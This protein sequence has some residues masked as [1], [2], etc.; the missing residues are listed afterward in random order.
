MEVEVQRLVGDELV[1]EEAVVGVDAVAHEGDEVAVVDAADDVHLGAELALALPAPR[2]E[3]LDG[4]RLPPAVV[5]EQLAAV[6]VPEPAL[7]E[8][9]ALGEAVRRRHQ[10]AVRHRAAAR[11]R[12]RWRRL[13]QR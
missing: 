11:R 6:H 2:P 12:W 10:V 8:Q 3:L 13:Q 7:P 9:V 1:D 4:H 5:Q